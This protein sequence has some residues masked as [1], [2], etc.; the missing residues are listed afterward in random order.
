MVNFQLDEMQEM[1]RELA[2]DFAVD[3]IRPNAEH[4]DANSQYPKE[5]IQAAHEMGLLNLHIPEDYGGP[6]LGTF[7][8]V[9]VNEELAWGDPGFATAAYATSLA[10]APIITGATEEQKQKWLRKVSEDGALASYGVTEPGA[11][12]DLAACKTTAIR[13]GDEYVINGSKMFITGAGYADFF[14]ILAKTDPDAG[15][16]GMSGFIVEAGAEGFTLGKKETNMGQRCSDTRAITFD[17]VRVPVENLI[18]G[19]ESGGWMNA[20]NAFDVSRPNI[21]AHATGLARAAYEHALQYSN[22]RHSF[23]KPL[24]KHQAIQ[25]MLADMKTKIEA[26]RLL[27]WKSAYESDNE[28]RNTESAAHAKRFSA[29][30]A[31]QITTDAVQIFGGYGYSEEYPVARLMRGAKVMQIYEGSSQVQRMIIGREITKNF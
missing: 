2:H 13:D 10:C 29:D 4:W 20:M 19:S 14:F 6:G 26:S 16:K 15:Y 21:A 31:M 18:G 17:N 3:E 1:L 5:A 27:T 8:E 7:E 30:A 23:G 24:H 12:S 9:L 25:F 28:I 11:G 22:E